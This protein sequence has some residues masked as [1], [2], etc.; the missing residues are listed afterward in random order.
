VKLISSKT[1]KKVKTVKKIK[2]KITMN[3]VVSM[4]NQKK[5]DYINN[6]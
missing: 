4:A 6:K 3:D 5:Q 2:K 1:V